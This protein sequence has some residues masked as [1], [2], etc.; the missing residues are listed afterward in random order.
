MYNIKP[1]NYNETYNYCYEGKCRKFTKLMWLIINERK[2]KNG[3]R[4]IVQHLKK[5]K[6][7]KKINYINDDGWTA[8][9]IASTMSN[10][11]S[12]Y[13]TIKLLIKLGTNVN[14]KNPNGITALMSSVRNSNVASSL[15]TVKLLLDNHADIELKSI[16]AEYNALMYACLYTG[17][18]CTIE[19]MKILLDRGANINSQNSEGETPL[20][21]V[22]RNNDTNK[23]VEI[24]ELLLNRGASVSTINN[25]RETS[26][27]IAVSRCCSK[28]SVKIIELLL[29]YGANM[30]Y[31][32]DKGVSILM[33]ALIFAGRHNE[34]KITNLLIKYGADINVITNNGLN[35]LMVSCINI[36]HID[37]SNVIKY[38]LDFGIDINYTCSGGYTALIHT[39][40]FA[41]NNKKINTSKRLKYSEILLKHGAN[42]NILCKTST[43]LRIILQYHINCEIIRLLLQYNLN[44]NIIVDGVNDLLWIA[45][46]VKSENKL[47]LLSLLLEYGANYEIIDNNGRTFNDF[48]DNDEISH[49][50]K[51]I[52]DIKLKKDNMDSVIKSIPEIVPEYI[53]D[54]NSFSVQLINL[55]W[56]I[57]KYNSKQDL[58]EFYLKYYNYFNAIDIED[59]RNKI[60]D[61]SK[62]VY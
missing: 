54:V 29:K 4:K 61:A 39:L 50:A 15:Q 13:A 17:A 10:K 58:P 44:T 38:I 30:E 57:N 33:Q 2:I 23:L 41:S 19:T 5:R 20:M 49:C 8:L 36:L 56:N 48:I 42:P 6:N 18:D 28:Y 37:N 26:L 22:L 3:H 25:N 34:Y 47:E 1:Y 7:Q 9:M 14:I 62:Y 45:K 60:S 16:D 11:W 21:L 24:V 31:C 43:I 53:Y 40:L 46:N 51:I 52:D 27:M 35:V 55:K 12:S 32:N 59:F